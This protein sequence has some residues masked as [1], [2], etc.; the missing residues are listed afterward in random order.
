MTFSHLE[1]KMQQSRF[2]PFL[3]AALAV[4]TVFLVSVSNA[5]EQ[6][7]EYIATPLSSTVTMIK[8]RGGNIAVSYGKM[9]YSLS[10]I[11]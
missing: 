10:M 8:G 1:A 2:R 6:E 9:A 7:V 5:Q 3:T 4:L 11:R